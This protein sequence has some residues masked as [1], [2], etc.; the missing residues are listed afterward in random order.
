MSEM[1]ERV[2][3]AMKERAS[4]PLG[5]LSS[6][7]TVRVGSLGD[8]WKY[9]AIA[10]IE[11]LRDPPE[12]MCKPLAFGNYT[13][14]SYGGDDSF[15]YFSAENARDT[16]NDMIENALAGLADPLHTDPTDSGKE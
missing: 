8:A 11:A 12:V 4:Q 16:W 15:D 9:L 7:E 2:A 14:T 1:V 6:L 10:A 13:T 5:N 3:M